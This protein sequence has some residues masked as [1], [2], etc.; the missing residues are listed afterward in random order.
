VIKKVEVLTNIA[1][2]AAAIVL[3]AVLAKKHLLVSE[4][5]QMANVA[6]APRSIARQNLNIGKKISV[7]GIE[8]NHQRTLL[9]VLSTTCRFCTESAPLYQTLEKE[10]PANVRLIAVLPQGLGESRTYL[11][12]LGLTFPDIVQTSLASVGVSGTPALILVDQSGLVKQFWIGKL[13]EAESAK[14]VA[15][16]K[17][18]T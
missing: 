7:P 15:S 18:G 3:C 1:V 17:R 6:A 14:L 12:K 16:L 2:I 5:T 8:W 10:K 13:P 4:K 9:L 11:T